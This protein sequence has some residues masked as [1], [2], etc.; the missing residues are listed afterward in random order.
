MHYR[1]LRDERA[2]EAVAEYRS[3]KRTRSSTEL[4]CRRRSSILVPDWM[5]LLVKRGGSWGA[6]VRVTG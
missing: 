2:F 4:S 1:Q 6:K 3:P 5:I